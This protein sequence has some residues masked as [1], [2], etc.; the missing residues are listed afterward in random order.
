MSGC[1]K[2]AISER[3]AWNERR[4][5]LTEEDQLASF[6]SWLC[7]RAA[8]Y[9]NA[10]D[11]DPTKGVMARTSRRQVHHQ[12]LQAEET[13]PQRCTKCQSSHRLDQCPEFAALSVNDRVEWVRSSNLC[14]SC[15]GSQHQARR[16]KLRRLCGIQGCRRNHHRLLHETHPGARA[17]HAQQKTLTEPVAFGATQAYLI[18]SDGSRV[19]V[20]VMLDEC[21]NTTVIRQKVLQKLGLPSEVSSLV[22]DGAGGTQKIHQSSRAQVT[23]ETL[24]CEKYSFP[25]ISLDVVCKPVPKID[26]PAM[27]HRWTHLRDLPLTKSGGK[28]T[29]SS[30]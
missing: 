7:D 22:L 8:S 29:C 30:G 13:D 15:F 14:F 20:I 24:T 4:A 5:Y 6:S 23:L 17:L 11:E 16:C 10:Y 28:S 26:W 18:A 2:L 21:S 12:L 27:Q 25:A 1:H 19:L 9:Q 3:Q